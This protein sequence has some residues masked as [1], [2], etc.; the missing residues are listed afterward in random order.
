MIKD[1]KTV[2]QEYAQKEFEK[3][4]HYKLLEESWPDHD[5]IFL[6][7]IYLWEKNIWKWKWSSKKK[8]QEEAAK[9]WYKNLSK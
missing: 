9:D 6:V 4:P 8:A 3:T 2:I 1:Y 7:W 5:K